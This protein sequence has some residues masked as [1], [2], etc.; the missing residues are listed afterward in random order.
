MPLQGAS[1]ASSLVDSHF[2]RPK[3]NPSAV[4]PVCVAV[5]RSE[6]QQP[7]SASALTALYS[8]SHPSR[9]TTYCSGIVLNDP[10]NQFG[11]NELTTRSPTLKRLTPAPT[12]CTSPAASDSGTRPGGTGQGY[13]PLTMT[14][15]RKLRELA[16]TRT[17]TSP[18]PGDGMSCSAMSM[19]STLP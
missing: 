13:P 6:I 18:T 4:H 7:A 19:P 2:G 8:V 3:P 11:K 1:A 16:R 9:S 17:S 15:S 10:P 5:H 12:A 14:M